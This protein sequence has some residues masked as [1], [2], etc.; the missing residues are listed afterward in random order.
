MHSTSLP[1]V[2]LGG[3][4]VASNM[5]SALAIGSNMA[6]KLIAG[7]LMTAGARRFGLIAV[8]AGS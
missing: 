5:T 3:T 6:G 7:Y 4:F 8:P 2:F 1:K